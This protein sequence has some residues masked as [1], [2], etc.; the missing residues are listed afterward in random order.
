MLAYADEQAL[1]LTRQTGQGWYWSRS[2]KRLWRK[3]E[4]SGHTQRVVE[5]R[6]DCD[7]DALLYLVEQQGPACHT[8][9]RSCFFTVLAA[10]DNWSPADSFNLDDLYSIIRER[11]KV[12]P[13]GS[14][15]SSLVDRG[16]N[17]VLQKVG[18]EAIE[19]V[20]ALR[21]LDPA[22]S[23]GENR[24]RAVEELADLCFHVLVSM[25]CYDIEPEE[26]VAE[27][28]TRRK[29]KVEVGLS[30]SSRTGTLQPRMVAAVSGNSPIGR[31]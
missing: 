11:I 22:A 12:R 1:A 29:D 10:D 13:S 25:A 6:S 27:L 16:L 3:G 5:V 19:A 28:G 31:H 2:R 18:E 23:A 9:Q 20:L 26:V 24:Q 7:H 15:V 17:R 21:D 30:R 4:T 8:G 14:Y